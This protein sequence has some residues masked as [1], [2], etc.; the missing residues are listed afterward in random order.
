MPGP[1]PNFACRP[2][3]NE[4]CRLAASFPTLRNTMPLVVPFSPAS[5][6]THAASCPRGVLSNAEMILAPNQKLNQITLIKF[7]KSHVS[8]LIF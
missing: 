8:I 1:F 6:L 7:V 4:L 5:I 3:D 2:T